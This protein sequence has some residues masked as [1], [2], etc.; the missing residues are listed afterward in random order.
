MLY[1]FCLLF[2]VSFVFVVIVVFVVFVNKLFSIL[3]QCMFNCSK[4][5]SGKKGDECK[6]F[7][8]VCLKGFFVVLVKMILQEKMKKCNV[9]V[10]KQLFKGGVCKIFMSICLKG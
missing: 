8:S 6:V 7:M 5:V 1:L 9:E 4:Q 2:V 3:Q 10:G